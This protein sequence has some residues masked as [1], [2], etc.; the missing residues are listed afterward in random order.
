MKKGMGEAV[1][2]RALNFTIWLTDAGTLVVRIVLGY[3][4]SFVES[5]VAGI[6]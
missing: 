4:M 6:F 5:S 2:P 3:L 1:L